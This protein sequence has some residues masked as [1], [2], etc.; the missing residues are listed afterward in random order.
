MSASLRFT[1]HASTWQRGLRAEEL[2]AN[3]LRS[4]GWQI[5]GRNIYTEY[6]EIDI[7][8]RD[9]REYVC[10]EVRSRSY[11]SSIPP[12]LSVSHSK[13]QHLVRSLLSLPRLHNQPVRIDLVTVEAGRVSDHF[14]DFR[15]DVSLQKL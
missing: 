4:L 6:G 10:V 3:E 9:G 5:L 2:V 13:Y 14:K 15:P 12:E 1:G 7:L 11:Q 8:A